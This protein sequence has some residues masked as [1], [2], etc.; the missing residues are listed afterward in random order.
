MGYYAAMTG[1]STF[2]RTC[3]IC[4]RGSYTD[5]ATAYS[6]IQCPSGQTT[7]HEGSTNSS[8][9]QGDKMII[10]S[11]IFQSDYKCALMSCSILYLV[12][13][14]TPVKMQFAGYT[15]SVAI[16][17]DGMSVFAPIPG[18]VPAVLTLNM[19]RLYSFDCQKI[20]EFRNHVI[21]IWTIRGELLG[22]V[23]TILCFLGR[24]ITSAGSEINF[25][26]FLMAH[27]I[28]FTSI[29][30][31]TTPAIISLTTPE[32]PQAISS[33][34]YPGN[35]SNDLSFGVFFLS[36]SGSHVE[37]NFLDLALGPSCSTTLVINFRKSYYT[38]LN[39]IINL[40]FLLK[41]MNIM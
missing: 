37:L 39:E 2:D 10:F 21:E 22:C 23:Y 4:P 27:N 13:I 26:R 19:V 14:L 32:E 28:L 1:P 33:P 6:C 29:L 25:E 40:R 5:T 11:N 35:Y 30:V 31:T 9:C 16:M 34:N 7:V 18:Q 3:M 36:P 20:H 41:M 24:L 8:N 38:I 15:T 17:T 12:Q